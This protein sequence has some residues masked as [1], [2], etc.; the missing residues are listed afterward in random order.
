MARPRPLLK[1]PWISWGT[2][3]AAYGSY[4]SFLLSHPFTPIPWLLSLGIMTLK[5]AAFT[6]LWRSAQRLVLGW[7]KSDLGSLAG[8]LILATL[9]VWA[10]VAF[11]SFAHVVVLLSATLLARVDCLECRF[12]NGSTFLWLITLALLGLGLSLLASVALGRPLPV[13]LGAG[14]PV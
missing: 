8:L 6:L 3:V 11:E 7:M 4:G 9:L 2:L 5:M 10:V 1:S 13:P 12:G 14:L